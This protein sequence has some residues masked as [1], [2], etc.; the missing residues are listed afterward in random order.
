MLI[1][2]FTK[3]K[4]NIKKLISLE[5]CKSAK[6]IFYLL[7]FFIYKN[8]SL[9]N[10]NKILKYNKILFF[11]K[12]YFVDLAMLLNNL[13]LLLIKYNLYYTKIISSTLNYKNKKNSKLKK[14][15]LITKIDLKKINKKKP[16]FSKN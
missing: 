3:K 1:K 13:N 6:N 16:K 9:T 2:L 14:K 8:I 11:Q 12:N 10:N 7:W 15:L 5:E 4:N